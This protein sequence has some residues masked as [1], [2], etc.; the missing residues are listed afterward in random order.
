MRVVTKYVPMPKYRR[1]HV[2][3]TFETMYYVPQARNDVPSTV[4]FTYH[5]LPS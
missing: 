3:R 5:V 4:Y 2:L 1:N